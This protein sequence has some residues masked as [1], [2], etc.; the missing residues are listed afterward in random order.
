[1]T[2][3]ALLLD[4]EGLA[5]LGG[6][7]GLIVFGLVN[8]SVLILRRAS[9]E[10]YQPSFKVPFYPVLP[11]LGALAVL[12]ILPG[13]GWLSHVSA[14]GLALGATAW[15]LWRRRSVEAGGE[16]I[17]PEYGLGDRLQELQ[18][19]QSLEDKRA[20]LEGAGAPAVPVSASVD[21]AELAGA[22]VVVELDDNQPYKQLLVLAASFGGRYQAPVDAIMVTEV[23]PQRPLQTQFSAPSVQWRR[24]M[25]ER[26]E[27]HGVPLR[28]HHILARDRARAILSRTTSDT[29][30]LLLDW[31]REFRLGNLLG[32]YVDAILR[33]SPSRVAVLKYRG[34][35]KYERILVAT[36]GSPYATAEVELADAV[37]SFTGASLTFMMVLPPDASE[38]REEQARAYLERLDELTENDA[39]LVLERDEDVARA[40]VRVGERHDLIVLGSSR[41]VSLRTLFGRHVV[42]RIADEVAERATG[43]VLI[44]KDPAVTRR[45]SRRLLDRLGLGRR[46]SRDGD[47]TS[48][49]ATV[50]FPRKESRRDES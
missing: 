4:V 46:K 10:W 27:E 24:K 48:A 8:V 2:S 23:P 47:I 35:K 20:A 31:H 36:A 14:V 44:T 21:S 32:S 41:E 29:R 13:M 6:A 49:D 37:A 34:H 45:V 7:F 30:I 40:I 3:L 1:M 42:G 50:V 38:A 11:A 43:S 26:M 28:F 39:H 17:Q 15:Y 16:R 18:Q 12:L 22:R 19:V 5:K 9:P 25:E 33:K